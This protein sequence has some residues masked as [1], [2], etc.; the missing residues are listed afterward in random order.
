MSKAKPYEIPKQTVWEA[1]KK[2]KANRGAAGIDEESLE[3]FE[4]DLK[5][6]LYKLWNRMASGSYFPPAVKVVEIPKKNGGTRRLGVPT[7]SDRIAQTLVQMYL[8]PQLEPIFHEDSYGYR[9][10]KSA[11]Q[12]VGQT[13]KRCWRYDW[14]L[15][16]DI[17]GAFDNID[18]ELLLRALRK[19]T[20]CKWVLL[21]IERWLTAPFQFEDGKQEQRAKGTPQGGVVSPLLMNLFLHYVF[22]S[23]M[24]KHYPSIPF[25]RYA[26][27]GVVHC[28]SKAEAEELQAALARRFAECKLE[29]H[30]EKTRIVYCKDSNRN[31]THENVSFDFLGYTLRGRLAKSRAGK[32]FCSFSP[33]IGSKAVQHIQQVMRDWKISRWTDAKLEMLAT[34]VNPALQGWYQYYGCYYPSVFMRLFRHF[35][36]ILLKWVRRKYKRLQSRKRS[37]QWLRKVA[38]RESALFFHWSQGV[39]PTAGQ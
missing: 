19:H 25:T 15:E 28:K 12:A 1:W 11:L 29:L 7:V 39:L 10:G 22:D 27:D 13:R 26:D 14:V 16:Y 37:E 4:S 17:R 23:W 18:H 36:R 3:T 38:E 34:R 9:P 20:D 33:A 35:N 2:V 6:N 5:G 31:G 30:P 21:Y 24:A 8:E 32:Y